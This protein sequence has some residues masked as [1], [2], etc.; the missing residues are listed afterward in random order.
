MS[1]WFRWYLPAV[2]EQISDKYSEPFNQVI[3][4][5]KMC[6][7]RIKYVQYQENILFRG[8]STCLLPMWSGFDSRTPRHMRVVVGSLL[9]FA[10]SFFSGYSDFALS[11]KLSRFD[12]I[13][14]VPS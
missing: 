9:W 11:P 5:M 7:M 10:L 14:S 3:E 12:L 13:C 6:E 1:P 8:E 4:M 2:K